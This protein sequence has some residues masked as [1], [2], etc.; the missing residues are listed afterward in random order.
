MVCDKKGSTQSYAE[1]IK[2]GHFKTK[3]INEWKRMKAMD[4]SD[5]YY[6]D[7]LVNGKPET[8]APQFKAG[9]KVRL[10]SCKCRCIKLF[11]AGYAGGKIT[12]VGNDG[13]DVNR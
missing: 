8:N 1:A 10:R 2:E 13:N 11:L 3:L 6:D 4:V 12:V 5:V 7:F 9:D